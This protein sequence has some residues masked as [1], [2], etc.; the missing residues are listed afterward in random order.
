VKIPHFDEDPRTPEF[1]LDGMNLAFLWIEGFIPDSDKC[2]FVPVF[3]FQESELS[4]Q[5]NYALSL[6]A[7]AF[8][9]IEDHPSKNGYV[10][11]DPNGHEFEI[12]RCHG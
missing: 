3:E 1:A 7:T 2:S 8:I 12:T 5:K 10:L 11:I 4:T 9:D 6:V